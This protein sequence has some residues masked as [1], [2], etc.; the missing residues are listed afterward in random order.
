MV[1]MVTRNRFSNLAL[2]RPFNLLTNR[3]GLLTGCLLLTLCAVQSIQAE[4]ATSGDKS[5]YRIAVVDM[6]DVLDRS[7]Q[8]AAESQLL[9]KKYGDRERALAKSQESL[10]QAEENFRLALPSL[11][12]SERIGEES[13]LRAKQRVVKR[14][15]ED[16]REE[17]RIAKD[18]A[19]IRLQKDVYDAIKAV[20]EQESIDIVFRE[21]DYIVADSKLD[22]T[23]KVLA[24]LQK[25]FELQQSQLDSDSSVISKP[26]EGSKDE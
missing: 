10:V 2:V 21:G 17:V 15:R 7:P 18:S 19:L 23:D 20:R 22:I 13:K 12:D 3:K 24:Y 4:T 5:V 1:K 25:Q 11:S 14:S 26:D 8:S 6:A 9:D 16:L